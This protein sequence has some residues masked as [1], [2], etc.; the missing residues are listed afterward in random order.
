MRLRYGSPHFVDATSFLCLNYPPNQLQT[1]AWANKFQVNNFESSSF[2]LKLF[3]IRKPKT[4]FFFIYSRLSWFPCTTVSLQCE[5]I[6]VRNRLYL[7]VVIYGLEVYGV[8]IRIRII[9][10]VVFASA[11][12]ALASKLRRTQRDKT[13]SNTKLSIMDSIFF[14]RTNNFCTFRE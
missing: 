6:A 11:L 9:M 14:H 4:L 10:K 8:S 3:H 2:S 7:S 13:L 5:I 1:L 12:L